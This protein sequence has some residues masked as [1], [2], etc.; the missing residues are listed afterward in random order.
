MEPARRSKCAMSILLALLVTCVAFT[1][2][3]KHEK[4]SPERARAAKEQF[5]AIMKNFHI[6]SANTN[7]T[8]RVRLQN[9]AAS[10][11]A[12]L[13]KQFPGESNICA[14]ALRGM[15][16]IYAAQT[17]LSAAVKQFILVGDHYP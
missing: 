15:G 12:K 7:E 10:R 17:N 8:E 6:P 9:E 14:Q 16:N 4:N 1:A 3:S 11:Y 5:D 2:C 13:V